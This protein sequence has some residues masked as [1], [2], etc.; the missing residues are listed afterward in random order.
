MPCPCDAGFMRC[1]IQS[2][3]PSSAF[4]ESDCKKQF[5]L[6]KVSPSR[7]HGVTK[8]QPLFE[9][10]F[11]VLISENLPVSLMRRF[12]LP[13][14]FQISRFRCNSITL[15]S[16]KTSSSFCAIPILDQ[17]LADSDAG[18]RQT[19][20]NSLEIAQHI[21]R[22]I[23]AMLLSAT[24]VTIPMNRMRNIPTLQQLAFHHFVHVVFKDDI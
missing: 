13:T 16:P 4:R 11:H 12:R 5:G 14:A 17:A 2:S 3:G 18:V 6:S 24:Q 20:K 8:K 22:Q 7:R 21:K 1:P 10:I 15:V 19:V 9:V 23:D